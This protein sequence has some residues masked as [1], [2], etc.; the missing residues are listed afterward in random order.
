M[1]FGLNPNIFAWTFM[2]TWGCGLLVSSFIYKRSRGEL[3]LAGSLA[4]DPEL[5][6]KPLTYGLPLR[7]SID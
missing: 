6:D 1:I 5:P 2:V 7:L 3:S 4:L